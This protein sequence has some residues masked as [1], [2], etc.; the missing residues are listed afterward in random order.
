MYSPMTGDIKVSKGTSLSFRSLHSIENE[1]K[2]S[3]NY[4]TVKEHSNEKKLGFGRFRDW[5][6]MKNTKS[7]RRTKRGTA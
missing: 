1:I 5:E 7:V 6:L 2:T 4:Y 3:N